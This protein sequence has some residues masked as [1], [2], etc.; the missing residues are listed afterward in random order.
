MVVAAILCDENALDDVR[1]IAAITVV[2]GVDFD[3]DIDVRIAVVLCGGD[4]C[5]GFWCGGAGDGGVLGHVYPLGQGIVID[6]HDL[7]EGVAHI[8]TAVNGRIGHDVVVVASARHDAVLDQHRVDFTVVDGVNEAGLHKG[9]ERRLKPS[10]PLVAFDD[11]NLLSH[12]CGRL[13]FNLAEQPF[14]CCDI[15]AFIFGPPALFKSAAIAYRSFHLKDAFIREGGIA[16]HRTVVRDGHSLRRR[17]RRIREA[18]HYSVIWNSGDNRPL[19]IVPDDVNGILEHATV[20]HIGTEVSNGLGC[21]RVEI[22]LAFEVDDDIAHCACCFGATE[23]AAPAEPASGTV[24]TVVVIGALSHLEA[25]ELRTRG[26][27]Q[28]EQAAG[29]GSA[30]H[31]VTLVGLDGVDVPGVCRWLTPHGVL[32]SASPVGATHTVF[33]HDE[34]FKTLV[35]IVRIGHLTGQDC[36]IIGILCE[37]EPFVCLFKHVAGRPPRQAQSQQPNGSVWTDAHGCGRI[38]RGH[39]I[40]SASNHMERK[41]LL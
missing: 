41:R 29:I 6:H 12:H 23:D 24:I 35:C 21:A 33:V 37:C 30:T 20:G 13:F 2:Q 38:A 26:M 39:G 7:I 17:V 22:R 4:R 40:R 28:L 27:L 18:R 31:Q 32:E 8:A 16:G 10:G 5:D 14:G 11:H 19:V 9:R 3:H 1:L 25:K 36:H 15:A 34:H